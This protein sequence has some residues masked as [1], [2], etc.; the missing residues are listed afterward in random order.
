[1]FRSFTEVFI[2]SKRY[3]AF[4]IAE[5]LITLTIVSII[6]AITMPSL[7]SSTND[8][9]YKLAYKKAYSNLY[10]AL[11][12]ANADKALKS[13]SGSYDTVILDNFETIMS[14]IKTVKTCYDYRT[15][16]QS[17]D[18]SSCWNKDGEEFNSFS[19]SHG[20]PA[21]FDMVAVDISGMSW[22]TYARGYT[23]DVFVD[24]NG[25]KKPN[26]FG[27]DRFILALRSKSGSG[28]IGYPITARPL[29][30][31][32]YYA[33]HYNKCETENNYYGTSWLY[34]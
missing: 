25:H 15:L 29:A 26:Q 18:N 10:S 31:N 12:R 21:L 32:N 8:M 34:K 9:Q 19:Y 16:G 33:C 1:M 27:K 22:A 5:V 7:I 3:T 6:A 30:D 17:A 24:T 11:N 28:S 23:F 2:S 4:T 20:F 14:Y 13:S